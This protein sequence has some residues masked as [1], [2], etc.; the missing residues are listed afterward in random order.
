MKTFNITCLDDFDWREVK[1]DWDAITEDI[2]KAGTPISKEGKI[3]ND[4]SCYGVLMDDL[5]RKRNKAGR[6]I[7]SGCVDFA[8]AE[9]H[10][11]IALSAA[12]KAA[13]PD[14]W[15]QGGGSGPIDPKRLPEGY[16]YKEGSKT[17]IE[18]DGNTDGLVSVGGL[19]YKVSDAILDNET[20]KNGYL[21][22][23][24]GG[25]GISELALA[26]FW[27]RMHITD[28]FVVAG[29][30]AIF[31]RANN[32]EIDEMTFPE[33]GVYFVCVNGLYGT[34]F[35]SETETIHPMAP[36]FL[37]FYTVTVDPAT[38]MADYTGAQIAAMAECGW[39]TMRLVYQGQDQGARYIY[40]G[41]RNNQDA[42][43]VNICYR[44]LY[45]LLIQYR[46]VAWEDKT[47]TGG[48][49]YRASAVADAAGDTPTAAEFNALLA[50]LRSAGLLASS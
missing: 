17:V 41:S 4:G 7:I 44:D 29:E 24:F 23:Y 10:S 15:S 43:F 37:P 2:I 28:E 16:P 49:M 47:T 25:N 13:M 12:A 33:A 18:W 40:A 9:A 36:E 1:I 38:N 34:K 5:Q 19:Y 20:I 27:D 39:V 42:M 45:G 30:Y 3:A 6:V 21:Y 11:G 48:Q 26:S 35:V 50:T 32:A 46:A 22:G 31:V 14:V 8:Q